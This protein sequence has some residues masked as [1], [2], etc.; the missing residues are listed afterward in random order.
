[1]RR[2][3]D[4][5]GRLTSFFVRTNPD[6][7]RFNYIG[8]WHSHP[9]FELEPSFK[10][11]AS[12]MEILLDPAVGARSVVLVLVKLDVRGCLLA[13]AYLYLP[14]AARHRCG[15]THEYSPTLQ[16]T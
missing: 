3:E 4:A 15:L 8:E 6:Y 5:L 16:S 9:I 13:N 7:R 11:D 2:I 12:M 10:D 1:V 14:D